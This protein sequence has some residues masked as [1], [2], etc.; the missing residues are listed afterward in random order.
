MKR[1][2]S[3]HCP[4]VWPPVWAIAVFG[5]IYGVLTGGVWLMQ[6]RMGNAP[7]NISNMEDIKSLYG[8]I[9]GVAAVIYCL[10]RLVRFHPAGNGRYAA[11]L[12]LSPWTCNEPLPLGPIH[13]VWQDVALIGFL[14]AL[15]RWHTHINA[16][17]P[18]LS[19]ALTY[20]IVLT[21][22]LARTRQ[23]PA[24]LGAAFLWPTFILPGVAGWPGVIL[25]FFLILAIWQ[26]YR[27]SLRTFP[28][29]FLSNANRTNPATSGKSALNI[30]IRLDA[31]GGE[32]SSLGWP[33]LALSP[34]I[35]RRAISN[36]TSF[37]VSALVGWWAYCIIKSSGMEALPWLI[38]IVGLVAALLRLAI[39]CVNVAPP[40]NVWGRMVSG[41]IVLPG[42]DKVFLTPLAVVLL[43][44]VAGMVVQ[45]SGSWYAASESCGLALLSFVLL[46]GGPTLRAWILTG[47]LRFRPGSSNSSGSQVLRRV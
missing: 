16:S 1:L 27:N 4:A 35:K 25:G 24:F 18:L 7:V 23:W 14:M 33:Y 47:Q 38:L 6:V 26:G 21:I 44:V 13:P 40:F 41:R 43:G 12:G 2:L 19:F 10:Y 46:A 34:K 3:F 22:L 31:F 9:S 20:L 39:Y 42:F 15:A 29:P 45:H 11:W 8:I 30:E 28:W 32:L 36:S 37:F 17:V 5:F